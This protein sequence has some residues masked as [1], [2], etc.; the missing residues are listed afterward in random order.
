MIE[1]IIFE[2]SSSMLCIAFTFMCKIAESNNVVSIRVGDCSVTSLH[3]Y[4]II[5]VVIYSSSDTALNL[6][7]EKL[8]LV[9]VRYTFLK[10]PR[11]FP[12][13]ASLRVF[14]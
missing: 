4:N 12:S 7:I 5:T 14:L 3:L 2:T 1:V 6:P 9:W 11:L 10:A 13:T 8:K